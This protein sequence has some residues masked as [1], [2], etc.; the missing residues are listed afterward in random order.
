[1]FVLADE[2]A[3]KAKFIVDALIS[4]NIKLATAESCTGGLVS[5]Y[6][7]NIA[8]SSAMFERGFVTYSNQ[9]KIDLLEVPQ[10]YIEKFG[11]VS[12]ETAIAMAE[13][14]LK[15]SESDIAISVTGIAGPTAD[16]SNKPL[17]SVYFAIAKIND[18][19]KY[20]HKIFTGDRDQVRKQSVKY[21]FKIIENIL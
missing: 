1:M 20:Y 6:L 8:G 14:A 4:K 19:T 11:A 7:T 12:K 18:N 9:A 2:I 21:C 17:G 13:G 5:A 10:I 3:T 16:A 15:K